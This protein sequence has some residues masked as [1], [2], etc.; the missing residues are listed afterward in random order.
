MTH[1]AFTPNRTALSRWHP[2][3]EGAFSAFMSKA[4]D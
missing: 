2:D 3:Y 4:Q 1:P